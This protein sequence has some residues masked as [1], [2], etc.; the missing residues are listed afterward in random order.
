MRL[1]VCGCGVSDID[2]DGDG[3]ADCIDECPDGSDFTDGDGDGVP[4]GCDLCP[5]VPDG[6]L[7]SD[8]DGVGDACDRCEGHDDGMDLDLDGIP[9]GC[10]AGTCVD[11]LAIVGAGE[12]TGVVWS[13]APSRQQ[14]ECGGDD[15][16]EVVFEWTPSATGIFCAT[17]GGSEF[18]AVLYAGDACGAV[19]SAC[20]DDESEG[21]A[22]E[23][24]LDGVAGVPQHV[25][26]DAFDSSQVGALSLSIREGPCLGANACEGVIP[27]ARGA[28]TGTTIGRGQALPT[29]CA[30]D[31]GDG[32]G[33]EAV[34]S[35]TADRA[36]TWCF[37]TQGTQF[38]S[39]LSVRDDC[40][41]ASAERACADDTGV[42]RWAQLELELEA[43]QSI[44][45][46][47]DGYD[48]YEA[49]EYVMNVA[50]G[51]CPE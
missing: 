42:E 50:R 36:G 38:D 16:S 2:Y 45:V 34:H 15:G 12:F 19:W 47:V 13:G 20:D 14:A 39:V 33:R 29:V 17:T 21:L 18:D 6:Q 37:D 46:V 28:T 35:F 25:V 48:S 11:P 51:A 8:G 23:L 49:G 10:G 5:A 30:P 43:H 7:D 3:A 41:A 27:I 26:V 1:G 22:A 44:V 9:D 32:S 31:Q 24:Q 40:S 4:D